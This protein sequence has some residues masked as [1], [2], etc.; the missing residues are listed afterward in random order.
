MDERNNNLTQVDSDAQSRPLLRSEVATMIE[1][2]AM[3]AEIMLPEEELLP[4]I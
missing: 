2:L 3:F 4:E 1:E